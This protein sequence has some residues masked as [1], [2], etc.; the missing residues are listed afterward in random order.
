MV[1]CSNNGHCYN[2]LRDN[3]VADAIIEAVIGEINH[4]FNLSLTSN[5]CLCKSKHMDAQCSAC[6]DGY[7]RYE[8][9]E[10]VEEETVSVF[11]GCKADLCGPDCSGRGRCRYERDMDAFACTCDGNYDVATQCATCVYHYTPDS[12]CTECEP[13]YD[14]DTLCSVCVL[15]YDAATNC[16]SCVANFTDPGTGCRRC[17][18]NRDPGSWCTRCADGMVE[19]QN[20]DC[21][22]A[23]GVATTALIVVGSLLG[24][25]AVAGAVATAVLCARRRNAGRYRGSGAEMAALVGGGHE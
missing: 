3:V 23:A 6:V 24:A 9:E 25:A 16:T 7:R 15:G 4:V 5:G 22:E 17:V 13:G 2:F 10:T 8:Q 1:E 21:V 19:D 18:H 20:G 14:P 11:K 12:G